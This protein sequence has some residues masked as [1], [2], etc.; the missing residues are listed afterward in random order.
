M[1]YLPYLPFQTHGSSCE[2]EVEV[3]QIALTS[4]PCL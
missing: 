4:E 2:E 1:L 3:G